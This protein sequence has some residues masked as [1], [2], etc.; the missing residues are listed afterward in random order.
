MP[1]SA[2]YQCQVCGDEFLDQIPEWDH[3][4]ALPNC[5]GEISFLLEPSEQ[6]RRIRPVAQ[7]VEDE[8]TP[9]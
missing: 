3:Y 8:T 2:T 7:V 5:C 9:A 4:E 6:A 1:Q